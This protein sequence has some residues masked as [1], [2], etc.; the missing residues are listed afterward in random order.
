MKY[1]QSFYQYLMTQ[2]NP[3]DHRAL[4]E[5][6]N[7]AFYDQSFPKQS[8][9]YDELSQYL[10]LNG[11]YLPGMTVFDEAWQKYLDQME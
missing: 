11:S 2:R 9:D 7:R 10:E 1:R 6:A 4:A 5:F 3:D 8:C